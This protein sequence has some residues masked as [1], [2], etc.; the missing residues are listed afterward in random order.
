MTQQSSLLKTNKEAAWAIVNRMVF[1]LR[2]SVHTLG[3]FW[4]AIRMLPVEEGLLVLV[5][6]IGMSKLMSGIIS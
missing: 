5:T 6:E 2:M 3:K 1:S 4:R